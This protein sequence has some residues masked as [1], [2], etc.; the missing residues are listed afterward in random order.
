MVAGSEDGLGLFGLVMAAGRYWYDCDTLVRSGSVRY[1]TVRYSRGR[2]KPSSRGGQVS[3]L[4]VFLGANTSYS[5]I[6]RFL[7]VEDG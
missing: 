7:V 3:S 5:R 6:G 2:T 1:V 4:E